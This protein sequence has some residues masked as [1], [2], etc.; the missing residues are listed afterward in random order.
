[1]PH[2]AGDAEGRR[3][4]R[5][6]HPTEIPHPRLPCSLMVGVGVDVPP[7]EAGG[8]APRRAGHKILA[9]AAADPRARDPA[10]G[11]SGRASPGAIPAKAQSSRAVSRSD[12][13][14]SL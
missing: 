10:P 14:S 1:M 9:K 8:M 11:V 7:R 5:A 3:K 2:T 12:F 13:G 4:A 6:R